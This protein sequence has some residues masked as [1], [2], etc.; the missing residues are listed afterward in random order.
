[1]HTAEK[2]QSY[3][4]FERQRMK[5]ID[6]VKL[7]YEEFGKGN[8]ENVMALL[9]DDIVW[10][11]VGSEQIPYFGEYIGHSGVS[12]FFQK[13]FEVEDVAEFVPEEFIANDEAV[14]V[15]GREKCTAKQTGREF[16]AQW[17][18]IF[19]VEEGKITNWKEIIDT[20]SMVLAYSSSE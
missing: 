10:T 1:M 12:D 7:F 3:N 18:Q 5:P 2:M 4:N 15:L 13:L 20:Y 16:E 6:V 11:L 17:A 9:H 14:V 19:Q 8:M